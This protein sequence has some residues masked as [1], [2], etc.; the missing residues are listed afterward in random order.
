MRKKNKGPHTQDVN[1]NISLDEARRKNEERGTPHV[2]SVSDMI[3]MLGN[4]MSNSEE[5]YEKTKALFHDGWLALSEQLRMVR[6][7]MRSAMWRSW[8]HACLD[9]ECTDTHG[10]AMGFRDGLRR[11]RE[12]LGLVVALYAMGVVLRVGRRWPGNLWPLSLWFSDM[13]AN[14]F[15]MEVNRIALGMVK[16]QITQRCYEINEKKGAHRNTPVLAIIRDGSI[17]L[18]A[19]IDWDEDVM[20][21]RS[22]GVVI[23]T[24]KEAYENALQAEAQARAMGQLM[25]AMGRDVNNLV[26]DD[27]DEVV[28]GPLDLANMAT[29]GRA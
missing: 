19:P 4:P 28:S 20:K 21:S 18:L 11:F 22:K 15:P 25:R 10:E 14:L 16:E 17:S 29:V 8:S 3:Q 26:E 24:I 7:D 23:E 12:R 5:H 2:K 9:D 27:D 13:F 6:S 1:S